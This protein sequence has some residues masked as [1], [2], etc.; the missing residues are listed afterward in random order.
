ME[1]EQ[2]ILTRRSIRKY[3]DKPVEREIIEKIINAGI[4]A[5]SACNIQGW[6][7]IVVD[8]KDIINKIVENG[9]AAF[10][11]NANQAI[12]VVYDNRTDNT[13]YNDYIQS[14]AAC[15][16]NM[17]L[18]AHGLSVGTCWVNFLPSKKKF[19]KILSIPESFDPIALISLGYYEQKIHER[20]RKYENRELIYW[21]QFEAKDIESGGGAK[22]RIK[23]IM[24]KIYFAL[25]PQIKKKLSGILNKKEKKFDN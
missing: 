24:R 4:W 25:P 1:L 5:P 10:L 21:N 3:N 23:R 20:P 22:L 6:R 9:A 14:A 12:V 13:E 18:M 7:F 19:R 2:A 8:D 17:L 15:I 16:E 11:K